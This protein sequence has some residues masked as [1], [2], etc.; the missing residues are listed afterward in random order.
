MDK[1]KIHWK[2]WNILCNPKENGGLGF[3]SLS[4]FNMA[5]LSKQ[6]WRIVAEPTSLIAC[7]YKAKYFPT[8]SFWEAETHSS[9]SYSWRSIFSTREMLKE[10][11]YWQV[12]NGDTISVFQDKWIHG[13]STG[14]PECI[15]LADQEVSVVSDLMDSVGS[16]DI[17]KVQRLFSAA[18]AT[19]I[20][21]IPLSRRIVVDRLCWRL[22]MDGKFSVKSMY[23]FV[24]F[25]S[26]SYCPIESSVGMKFW[27]LLWKTHI[28]NKARY[29][30]GES[31]LIFC[32]HLV[33]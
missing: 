10:N 23:R 16:W 8:C 29:M 32:L 13:S 20:L 11:I 19:R 2:R 15:N 7:I 12:G 4:N 27:K 22:A 5:M 14:V 24:F 25:H 28:P 21:N 18:D 17:A 30:L 31:V 6:A 9:P 1:H 26:P 3:R 33:V